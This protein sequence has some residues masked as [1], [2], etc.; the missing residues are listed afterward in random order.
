MRVVLLCSRM[1]SETTL[2]RIGRGLEHRRARPERQ[3]TRAGRL[4][5]RDR[6]CRFH[7]ELRTLPQSRGAAVPAVRY[8]P[9]HVETYGPRK[10]MRKM[11]IA[12]ESNLDTVTAGGNLFALLGLP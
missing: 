12:L 3:D 4:T 11:G 5:A 8:R 9:T 1:T 6:A 10:G 2:P 7:D